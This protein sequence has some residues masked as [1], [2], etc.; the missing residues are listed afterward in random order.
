MKKKINKFRLLSKDFGFLYAIKYYFLRETK[1]YDKY[2]ELVYNRLVSILKPIIDKYNCDNNYSSDMKESNNIWV[3]WWQGYDNMP[4]LCKMCYNRMLS[5]IPNGYNLVLNTK[6]N[7]KEY[8]EIPEVI[9]NKLNDGMIAVTQFSDILRNALIY[10]NGGLWLDVSIWVN[11]NFFEFIDNDNEFWSVKLHSIDNPN[12]WGQLISRCEWASFI[13][14]GK[15]NN[16]VSKFVYESMCYYFSHYDS[17]IDYFLQNMTIRIGYD[18]IERISAIIKSIKVSNEKIYDLY[19][20]MDLPFVD[21]KWKEL[22][23]NTGFFKL[24]QKREYKETYN[25]NFTFY[26]FLKSL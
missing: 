3:C 14:Y 17:T 12:I 7:Y 5:V 23:M 11:N 24:T 1:Q 9:I 26:S 6:D 25:G 20:Y 19:K 18:N 13:L 10:Y 2:V 4:L 15:K 16:I 21:S 8:V 22:C